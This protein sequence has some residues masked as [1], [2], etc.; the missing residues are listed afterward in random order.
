MTVAPADPGMFIWSVMIDQTGQGLDTRNVTN[1]SD[2][3]SRLHLAGTFC[4]GSDL[5]TNSVTI[6]KAVFDDT[7]LRDQKIVGEGDTIDGIIIQKIYS[8]HV[9][10]CHGGDSYD[11]WLKMAAKM[12][13]GTAAVS[14]EATISVQS[15]E[16]TI[17]ATDQILST[18]RFGL[19]VAPMRW[20][21]KRGPLV[22][23]Y[24]TMMDNPERM[25][26][27][28]D[29]L[30]PLYDGNRK[31]NGYKVGIDGEIDFFQEVGLREGDVVK[32]VNSLEMSNRRRAIYFINE[33]V[34]DRANIFVLDVERDGKV[35]KLIYQ[36]Q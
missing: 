4:I 7:G 31:I 8:D 18:N 16:T 1:V 26:K 14:N 17:F 23:Y 19:Q 12:D 20:L 10:V 21:F 13:L 32:A 6:R 28:F 22:E 3:V 33:F 25:A 11:I 30:K 2:I 36:V 27:L 24:Q 34:N 35:E 5:D 29:S 9:T 15:N